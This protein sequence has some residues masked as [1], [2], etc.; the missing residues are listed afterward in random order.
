MN[1]FSFLRSR[2][3]P[4]LDGI[5]AACL[6]FLVTG[7]CIAWL[8]NSAYHAAVNGL[9]SDLLHIAAAA[10][11]Q[12]DGDLHRKMQTP[13]QVGSP[14]HQK[15]IQPLV[16]FHK[17]IPQIYYLY[18]AILKDDKIHLILDTATEKEALGSKNN[19]E[20][21]L[22]M[23]EYEASEKEIF[24]ALR[25]GTAQATS[26]PIHDEFGSFLSAY[27]PFY[28]SQGKFAGIL[29]VD[30]IVTDFYQRLQGTINAALSSL[31]GAFVLSGMVGLITWRQRQR[32]LQGQK[33]LDRILDASIDAV[34]ALQAQRDKAGKISSFRVTLMNPAAR[35]LAAS[36][37][38]EEEAKFL[39]LFP[40]LQ[41]PALLLGL[42]QVVES[43]APMDREHLD[44]K[45]LPPRWLRVMAV[46]LDDGVAM[47]LSNITWRKKEESELRLA[48]D[49]AQAADRAKSEF[50]AMMSHEIRT[51]MNGILGFTNLLEETPLNEEQKDFVETISSSANALLVLLNDILDFSKIESGLLELERKPFEVAKCI[52][53]AV[54]LISPA[55]QSKG[56]ALH[57]HIDPELPS[58]IVG[59]STRLRQI[60]INLLGNAVKFTAKG[61]INLRAKLRGP[62]AIFEVEDTGIGIPPEKQD[63]LF[64]PFSQADSSTTRKYGG[65]GLGLAIC[66][67]LAGLMGGEISVRSQVQKGSTFILEI[68]A[69]AG[70]PFEHQNLFETGSIPL[71]GPTSLAHW[72]ALRILLAEDNAVNERVLRLILKRFEYEPDTVHNGKEAVAACAARTYDLVF[73]DVQMPEMDGYQA[74]RGIR[75]DPM[76]HQ[77]YIIALTADAM[78]GDQEKC[79]NAGMN[80]YLTK[81]VNMPKIEEAIIRCLKQLGK[82]S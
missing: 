67:R 21:S 24:T 11:S 20:P 66:K 23:D 59:D 63:R 6:V 78:H 46:K 30:L 82:I 16:R 58:H 56:L 65:T 18:T 48:R 31:A 54:N 42:H 73:M 51:P 8:Y 9:R 40:G 39:K 80:D 62:H 41:S 19:L 2:R 13:S 17:S 75:A 7:I 5:I 26:E 61:E 74:S 68:P 27:A 29:G 70:D 64:L 79:L 22:I 49:Q 33:K 69:P 37:A 3:N 14:D 38:D 43:G 55:A 12:V 71:P 35:A 50:L 4:I 1:R 45:T 25:T 72:P 15:L 44:E 36:S 47:T 57:T 32:E 34:L 77:P 52:Q 81:P 28:D 10:A 60:L 53:E 76:L